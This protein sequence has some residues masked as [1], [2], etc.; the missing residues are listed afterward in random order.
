MSE[1]I[2][3]ANFQTEVLDSKIPVIVDFYADWCGPCKMMDPVIH[4]LANEYNGR[5]KFSKC[6]IDEEMDL[7]DRFRIM[8]IPAFALFK[9]GHHLET[10]VGSQSRK[11]LAEKAEALIGE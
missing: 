4:V 11:Y 2:T 9:D 10:I 3:N 5:V 8:S 1:K 7:S 6:N